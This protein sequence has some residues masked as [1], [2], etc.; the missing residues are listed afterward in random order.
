MQL[1]EAH[2]A[3]Y[4]LCGAR[5]F[6]DVQPQH[7]RFSLVPSALRPPKMRFLLHALSGLAYFVVLCVATCSLPTT[8]AA[9]DPNLVLL[10]A[11]E[12]SLLE[13]LT[14]AWTLCLLLEQAKHAVRVGLDRYSRSSGKH[15]I[16]SA[17]AYVEEPSHLR[18]LSANL[19]VL[20]AAALRLGTRFG[21]F[22]SGDTE[23]ENARLRWCMT[24]YALAVILVAP[25][26]L[27]FLGV[28]RPAGCFFLVLTVLCYLTVSVWIETKSSAGRGL[29]VCP[30]H[31][32]R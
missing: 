8:R 32:G 16:S 19:V 31:A 1:E 4:H 17:L 18:E 10:D 30:R 22:V 26:V 14:W 9:D 29:R 5:F 7:S 12:L 2:A 11:S 25:R 15:A 6:R 24:L 28:S 20:A 27:G 23:W 13:W 3:L 21:A